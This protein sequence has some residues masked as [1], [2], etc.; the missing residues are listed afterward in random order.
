MKILYF[1]ATGNCLHVAKSLGGEL[2]SIPKMIQEGQYEFTDEK[3]GIVFPIYSISVPPYI[4]EFIK[5]AK[6]NCE[7]LFGVMT[8]GIFDGATS[9][10]LNNIG[11]EAG[12]NFA[13]INTIKMVDNWLPG[14]DME[15]QIASAP[16]KHIEEH[17]AEIKSDI[18]GSKE[19]IKKGHVGRKMATGYMVR[20]ASKPNHKDSLHGNTSGLG[21]KNFVTVEDT[22][23]KCGVC[24]RVCPVKNIKVDKE[25]GVSFGDFC[26]SCFACTH[27]CPTNAI[28]LKGERTKARFRNSHIELK[29]I[30]KSNN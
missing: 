29:E 26:I 19:F 16:K 25:Q 8:Y 9:G 24:S 12:H 13:Y 20:S 27:N 7:Y 4:E 3:I 23:V 30:I 21:I 15:K 2:Y 28:R 5:K 11:K 17:I 6:F 18:E 10:H 1:T 14:F 22:C